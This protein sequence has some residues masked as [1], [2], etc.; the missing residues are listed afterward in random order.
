MSEIT[1][2][3]I[4]AQIIECRRSGNNPI[5]IAKLHNMYKQG[6]KNG[7]KFSKEDLDSIEFYV[8]KI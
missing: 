4:R 5:V 3:K 8:A 1:L 6:K 2:R 7:L